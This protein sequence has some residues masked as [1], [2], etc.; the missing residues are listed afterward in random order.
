MTANVVSALPAKT[1]IQRLTRE[2]VDNL[3]DIAGLDMVWKSGVVHSGG[4]HYR[5]AGTVGPISLGEDECLIFGE[6]IEEFKP[7]NAFIIGNA[8]GMSS[9]LIAKV[10][11]ANLANSVI[12]LDSKSE[13]NGELCYQTAMELSRRM[14]CR[15][16]KN[17]VGSSPIDLDKAMEDRYYD[18]I[19]IDGD[20]SHPQVTRDFEGI[21]PWA[22][23]SSIL[24]WHDYWLKGVPESVIAAQ[25]AGYD[26]IKVNS[27]CEIV[28]G[29]RDPDIIRR[30]KSLFINTE[31][32][33][34]KSRLM[35]Y[36]K[37]YMALIRGMLRTYLW[38]KVG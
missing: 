9:V 10:M 8:F 4:P 26:C 31:P 6:L 30:I 21:Q 28:F 34:K 20:H 19:F 25:D 17:K 5:L 24:C 1:L 2:I 27:S 11:E 14:N 18:L 35:P 36:L 12:T 3:E 22:A 33:I 16:L 32:P 13:G 15:I 38:N 29:S 23:E 7:R 37:L